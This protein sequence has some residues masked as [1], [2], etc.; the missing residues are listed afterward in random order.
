MIWTDDQW[1]R[2]E[3]GSN[4]A[5]EEVPE[6]A[7]PEAPMPKIPELDEYLLNGSCT[8]PGTAGGRLI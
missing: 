5:K 3:D 6:S 1:L 7:L 2:M 4:P 8:L